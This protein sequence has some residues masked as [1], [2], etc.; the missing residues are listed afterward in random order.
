MS[1]KTH[2]A[3]ANKIIEMLDAGTIPWRKPW[4]GTSAGMPT[5]G[6]SK[7]E[8]RGI[9]VFMLHACG[10]SSPYWFSFN[11]AKEMG[12]NVRKGEH[13]CPV[14]FWKLF[15]YTET[16]DAGE[17]KIKKVPMLRYYTAFNAEQLENLPERFQPQPAD[18]V[19]H[20]P[21][22]AAQQIII[23]MPKPPAMKTGP[24][25]C[26]IPS[27]DTVE[28]PAFGAFETSHGYYSTAFHELA[29]STMHT[30]RLNRK[31]QN[32]A[33]FGSESYGKEE[34]L[35]EFAASYL[36]G[37]SGIDVATITN[38][39]AYIASWKKTIKATPE[40]VIYA[41]AQAQKAA[42]FILGRLQPSEEIEA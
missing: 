8:Y 11:Q 19:Q 37:A 6:K 40:I 34:L 30:S 15:P 9:N 5:N 23:N 42:D 2:E 14:I 22:E 39:A 38:S 16:N 4:N 7:K 28:L 1:N 24:Q 32:F 12:A 29:H 17:T 10:Y 26:Y 3:I 33:A 20:D 13:G 25:A 41:A 18:L 27:R 21:I 35:A 36:C 31:E